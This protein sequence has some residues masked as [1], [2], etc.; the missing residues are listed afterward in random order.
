M[1]QA[2]ALPGP[3]QGVGRP[4]PPPLLP[5]QPGAAPVSG[6]HP[7]AALKVRDVHDGSQAPS[8]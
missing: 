3:E 5:H 6:L 2:P 4:H 1:L 8:L 7:G